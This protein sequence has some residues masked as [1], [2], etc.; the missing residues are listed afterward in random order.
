MYL[1]QLRQSLESAEQARG[2]LQNWH[3]HDLER[4]WRN[5]VHLA[6]AVG[7]EALGDLAPVLGRLL[8]RC[9]DPDMALNNFERFLAN[10]AGAR[11]LP[12]LL[13]PRSRILD[14]L[15]QLLK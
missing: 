8:P 4:G 10:S 1:A 9:S 14:T 6:K 12:N 3:L 7:S 5:L 11:L 2:L 13:E 15:L